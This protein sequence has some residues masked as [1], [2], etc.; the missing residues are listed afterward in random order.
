MKRPLVSALELGGSSAKEEISQIL[1]ALNFVLKQTKFFASFSRYNQAELQQLQH[2]VHIEVRYI[3]ARKDL[4]DGV[5][6]YDLTLRGGTSPLAPRGSDPI[7]VIRRRRRRLWYTRI[8][9][10]ERSFTFQR[11]FSPQCETVFF[12]LFKL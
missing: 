3:Y 9:L 11:L 5:Q 8:R 7:I 6:L 1:Y 4:D 12:F 2:V 10:G